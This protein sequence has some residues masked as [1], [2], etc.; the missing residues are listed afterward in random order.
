M[1]SRAYKFLPGTL[2]TFGTCSSKTINP[3]WVERRANRDRLIANRVGDNE[4][5]VMGRVMGYEWA[6]SGL[7][8]KQ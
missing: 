5:R 1:N 3:E 4:N 7:G 8:N 6:I 2:C